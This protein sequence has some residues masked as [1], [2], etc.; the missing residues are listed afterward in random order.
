MDPD[1]MDE[2]HPYVL[3]KSNRRRKTLSLEVRRDGAVVVQA[4]VRTSRKEIEGFIRAKEK[5][6]RKRLQEQKEHERECRDKTFAT[7]ETFL[8]LGE[9]YPLTVLDACGLNGQEPPLSFTGQQFILRGEYVAEGK[10]LFSGWYRER[11]LNLITERFRYFCSRLWFFSRSIR[12]SN[13]RGRWGS[14]T[15]DDRIYISWRIVMAPPAVMD[16][17]IVHEILHLKEKNHSRRFWDLLKAVLPDY[18]QQR[19]WL[20]EKGHLL[21]M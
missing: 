1:L 15:A 6:L 21:E 8:F 2:T 10:I 14:C 3:M 17:V 18:K 20:R 16:Y 5:W 19:L 4:P 7:G 9:A 11:A 13:A 12:L